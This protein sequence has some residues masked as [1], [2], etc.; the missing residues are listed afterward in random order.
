MICSFV[1]H[2][3]TLP[4]NCIDMALFL[5]SVYVNVSI[6]FKCY[7]KGVCIIRTSRLIVMVVSRLRVFFTNNKTVFVRKLY[8]SFFIKRTLYYWFYFMP[9]D[10]KLFCN[11][12]QGFPL[13]FLFFHSFMSRKENMESVT[14]KLFIS[15]PW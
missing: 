11:Q 2:T 3:A 1:Y 14:F 4:P 15:C 5:F 13:I 7:F 6:P 12:Y 8:T 10:R 9:Y